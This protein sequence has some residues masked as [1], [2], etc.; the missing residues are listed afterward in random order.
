MEVYNYL[1]CHITVYSV[2]ITEGGGGGIAWGGW[3]PPQF[4]FNN[5]HWDRGE[6]DPTTFKVLPQPPELFL[7][8]TGG[9]SVLVV[10][11][12]GMRLEEFWRGLVRVG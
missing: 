2:R 9:G 8:S 4:K 6:S 1:R 3:H 11:I 10:K 5:H 7:Q 12:L